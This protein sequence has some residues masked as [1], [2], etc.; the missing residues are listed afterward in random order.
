M[1]K[2]DD[3]QAVATVA[4]PAK[5]IKQCKMRRERCHINKSTKEL[6]EETLLLS[7]IK[8]EE[9]ERKGEI[10]G[11]TMQIQVVE[12]VKVAEECLLGLREPN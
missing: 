12:I 5:Q 6:R 4:V 1:G 10:Q 9:R 2:F 3:G 11:R 8:Q 7:G